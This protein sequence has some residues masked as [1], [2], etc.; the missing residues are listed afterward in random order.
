M[1]PPVTS[2]LVANRG[3]VAVRIIRTAREMGIATVAAYSPQDMNSQACELADAAFN[4]LGAKATEARATLAQSYLNPEALIQVAE[5]GQ[6]D[7]VHPGYGFLSENADFAQ[8][9]IDAGLTWIG[10]DPQAIRALG[11]KISARHIATQ[12]G[13]PVIPGQELLGGCQEAEKTALALAESAGYPVLIKRADSGGGR[14][15]TRCDSPEE[16]QRFFA[17][18]ADDAAVEG[19]FVEKMLLRVRHVETQCMRDVHGN[20]A[21]VT[22]RDCSVQRRNQKIVEEA[23]APH[24]ASNVEERVAQYSEALFHAVDYHG[25]GTCEFLVSTTGDVYFLEVNPRLQVEHTVS[26]EVTGID[27]V[28]EQIRIAQG[29]ALVEVPFPRGHSIEV[30][31]TSENPAEDLMPAT[32][33]IHRIDWP[34]GHGVRVDSFIRSGEAIGADYD[35]L[36]AKLIVTAPTRS[37]ALAKLVRAMAELNVEGLP[38][39]APLIRHIVQHADFCGPDTPAHISGWPKKKSDFAVYTKWMEDQD[40]LGQVKKEIESA[41]AGSGAATA[42]AGEVQIGTTGL[43]GGDAFNEHSLSTA[44][45]FTIEFNGQRAHVRLPHALVSALGAH[46]TQHLSQVQATGGVSGAVRPRPQA[47]RG[48]ARTQR[49]AGSLSP[50]GTRQGGTRQSGARQGGARQG[51]VL[52]G[53]GGPSVSAPIQATVV[54]IPV[55]VGQEITEGDLLVVVESMKMEKPIYAHESGTIQTIHITVGESVKAGQLLIDIAAQSAPAQ[56][57]PAQSVQEDTQ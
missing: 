6:A 46:A 26:E 52:P 43:A 17:D 9:V 23:P 27:L 1:T 47:L 55:E 54:R 7:A 37:Q 3:E 56:S 34:G 53:A 12:A 32:G 41:A 24:L 29:E 38:T 8:A 14:G 20:F 30:R 49:G 40:L 21:V 44:Q 36:I 15:I 4:L 57:V 16:I 31:I 48:R 35:S 18:L 10:P 13:V 33:I 45:A 11:D 22:T 28:R 25:V 19:C 51:E 39:C 50:D 5:R 2:I 42:D